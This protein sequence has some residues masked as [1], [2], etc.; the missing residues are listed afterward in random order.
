MNIFDPRESLGGWDD[1][2]PV[3][4]DD[5]V[6]RWARLISRE[7]PWREMPRDDVRGRMRPLMSE[8]LN[9]ARDL[10]DRDRRRRLAVAAREH[11]AYRAAQGCSEEQL[12]D[13]FGLAI[14]AIGGMLRS[15]GISKRSAQATIE[16][17][18]ADFRLAQR[19]AVR[20]WYRFMVSGYASLAWLDR[21]IEEL[22]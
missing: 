17:L 10:D 11:G 15:V 16:S 7:H 8:L 4:V 19:S 18:G 20:A 6:R 14:V 2:P 9:E 22:G 21:L 13:E 3:H 5:V 1:A 12:A